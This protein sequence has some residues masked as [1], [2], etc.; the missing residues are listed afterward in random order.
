MVHRFSLVI[1]MFY[2]VY[3]QI[4]ININTTDRQNLN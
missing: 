1:M 3:N 2:D 4:K